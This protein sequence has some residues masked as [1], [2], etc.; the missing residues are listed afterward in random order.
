LFLNGHG[1]KWFS[2]K[3]NLI[4]YVSITNLDLGANFNS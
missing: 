3:K 1:I 4:D 2:Q